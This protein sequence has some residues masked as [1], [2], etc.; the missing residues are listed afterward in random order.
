VQGYTAFAAQAIHLDRPGHAHA[1]A[2]VEKTL[3][4]LRG[5]LG[6]MATVRVSKQ[7]D[8]LD[9]LDG[10]A[11]AQYVSFL[12]ETRCVGVAKAGAAPSARADPNTCN[13]PAPA[14]L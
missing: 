14:P 5:V 3:A 10:W 2:T 13:A 11:L 7:P 6:F 8:L 4:A 1:A 9:L 12:L